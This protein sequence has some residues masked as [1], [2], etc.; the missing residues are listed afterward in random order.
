MGWKASCILVNERGPGYLGTRLLHDP[1]RARSLIADLGLGRPGSL[2]MTRFDSGIYP[3]GLVVGA[4]DGAAILG[5][6]RIGEACLDSGADRLTARVLEVFPK[7]AVLRV[8]LHSVVNLWSYTYFEGGG[9][10]GPTAA[11]PTRGSCWKR[12]TRCPRSGPTSSG[13]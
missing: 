1:V 3:T 8:G 11:A 2:G 4:Y 6:P 9:C 10:S 7:A 12:A 13:P 5:D